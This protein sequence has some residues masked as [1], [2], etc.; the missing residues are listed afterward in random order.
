M[1]GALLH[2]LETQR[3]VRCIDG[4]CKGFEFGAVNEGA[5]QVQLLEGRAYM[6]ASGGLALLGQIAIGR[7]QVHISVRE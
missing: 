1:K 6:D 2:L 5:V 3:D 4:A 7:R